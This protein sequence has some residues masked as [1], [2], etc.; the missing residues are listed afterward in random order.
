VAAMVGVAP[1]APGNLL[2]VLPDD[3]LQVAA[4]SHDESL[5]CPMYT[6]LDAP[7]QVGPAFM[8]SFWAN[9]PR[10]P[11]AAF[12]AYAK[13]VVAESAQLV[14]ERFN[15]GGAALHIEH[16]DRLAQRPLLVVTGPL[17]PRHPRHADEAVA[18]LFGGDFM[19]LPDHGIEGNGHMLMIE[20]NSLQVAS[21]IEHWLRQR[22]RL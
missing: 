10:F 11:H 8:R 15:I 13:S 3:P 4:M 17:D 1:G 20:D 2:P 21:L 6:P 22:G 5:G 19:W 14:N 12:D 9:A 16:P 18:R 7:L